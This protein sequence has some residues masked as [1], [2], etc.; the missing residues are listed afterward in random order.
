M[1]RFI[2][3]RGAGGGAYP[4]TFRLAKTGKKLL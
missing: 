4:A 1:N 3:Y 2:N